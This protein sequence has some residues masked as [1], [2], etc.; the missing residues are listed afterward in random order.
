MGWQKQK[1]A[2]KGSHKDDKNGDTSL[3]RL[4]RKSCN[5]AL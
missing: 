2:R 4:W 3:C 1:G 5:R